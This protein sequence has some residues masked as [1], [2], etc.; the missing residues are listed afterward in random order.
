MTSPAEGTL[1]VLQ[2]RPPSIVAVG[3]DGNHLTIKAE[4]AG[5]PDGIKIDA[6]NRIAY[7]T[8]M[9]SGI[10][11]LD[12]DPLPQPIP[13]NDGTIECA[14][15]DGTGHRVLVASGLAGT[16]K[17]IVL[18]VEGG[19]L[20]WC[21]REGMRVM[22]ARLDGSEVTELVRT[23]NFPEDTEDATRHCVGIALDIP[24]K[25]LYWTQKGPPDGGL[26]RI[27]RAGIALP[28]GATATQ[29]PDIECLLADLPEPIDLD[30]DHQTHMLYWTDRGDDTHD[31]NSLNRGKITAQGVS[32]R[33]VL[34][35]GLK[36]GIGVSLDIEGRRAFVTDLAGNIREIDIDTRQETHFA[37]TT[38]LGALTGID[39]VAA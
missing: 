18:D 21:D 33:E 4:L 28:A 2:A 7:W 10:H 27:F 17:E 15:L 14:N 12:S 30:I 11:L 36:E 34:I 29:R 31:G 32:E 23:G 16:P 9:G 3:S 13:P 1:Y 20:Y 22:R 26:G 37:T 35:R 25:H 8:N 19:H 39:Y 6:A 24:N 5:T 38:H